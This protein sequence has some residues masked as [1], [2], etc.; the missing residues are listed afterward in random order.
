MNFHNLR[1]NS[2][3]LCYPLI[4]PHPSAQNPS[5]THFNPIQPYT[6]AVLANGVTSKYVFVKSYFLFIF[7]FDFGLSVQ[8]V[9]FL[10][11]KRYILLAF[12]CA[13]HT[14]VTTCCY[15]WNYYRKIYPYTNSSYEKN[16][17][18]TQ[19]HPNSLPLP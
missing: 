8:S 4:S 13:H 2:I 17:Q 19:P 5:F 15:L 14:P 1:K 12:R 7:F 18:K 9:L 10:L 3:R 16:L 6:I 11:R